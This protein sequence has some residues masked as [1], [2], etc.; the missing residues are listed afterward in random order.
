MSTS[1]PQAEPAG[2]KPPRR[3]RRKDLAREASIERILDAAE[4]MFAEY[5]YHGVTMK[6]VARK[7][8]VSPTLLHYHF[9][10]KESIFEAIWARKAPISVRK[11]LAAMQ[12]YAE[13]AGDAVTVE[14]ALRVWI[15]TDLDLQ[16]ERTD[17][18]SAFGRIVS[19]ANGAGGWGSEKMNAYFDPVAVALFDVLKKAMPG[20]SEERILWCFHFTSGA[21]T[22]NLA[23]TGRLDRLSDGRCSS[24]D[25]HSIKEHMVTFMAAGFKA[26]CQPDRDAGR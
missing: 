19:Q 20:T 4:Q 22:H 23:R 10:G 11:R 15:D 14:G 26:I 5:G 25:F 24:D 2:H 3:G 13:T 6:D 16:I 21:M 18:W 12:E 1:P 17:Y 7:I 9:N 8:G